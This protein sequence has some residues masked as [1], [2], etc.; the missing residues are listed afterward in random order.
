MF[1][2]PHGYGLG[3]KPFCLGLAALHIIPLPV[4][5]VERAVLGGGVLVQPQ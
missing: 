4:A 5:D 2:I 1:Q 3:V